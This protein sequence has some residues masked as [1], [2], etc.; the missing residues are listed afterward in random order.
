MATLM[1]NENEKRLEQQAQKTGAAQT[2]T[3]K[4][5]QSSAKTATPTK[6]TAPTHTTAPEK[7]IPTKMTA[8]VK[9][10]APVKK[11]PGLGCSS[12]EVEEA[13]ES[14]EINQSSVPPHN[15]KH[16]LKVVDSV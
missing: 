2:P 8:P 11:K 4:H 12:V 7:V 14:N 6:L 5:T 3:K 9:T 15:P 1:W 13:D 10:M 16:I